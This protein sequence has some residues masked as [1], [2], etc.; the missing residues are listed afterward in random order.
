ME[1][2]MNRGVPRTPINMDVQNS[3]LAMSSSA[4]ADDVTKPVSGWPRLAK[5]ITEKPDL[6]SFPTFKDLGIKSLLY[7]QAELIYLR[8][9]LHKA[10]WDDYR[11][12]QEGDSENEYAENLHRFI[13]AHERALKN[14]K[15]PPPQWIYIDRIRTVLEK[16]HAALL[17]FSDVTALRKAD[18][19]NINSLRTFVRD[20]CPNG[21]SSTGS[22]TW[23]NIA[24]TSSTTKSLPRLTL[25]LLTGFFV[26]PDREREEI[27]EVFQ[28]HL[29]VPHK[30]YKPDGLTQW[31]KQSFIPFFDHIYEHYLYPILKCI[32]SIWNYIV[33]LWHKWLRPVPQQKPDPE[34]KGSSVPSS[35]GSSTTAGV[36]HIAS[37]NSDKSTKTL[38]KN[39]SQYSGLCIERI[40]SVI[41][42]VV[43][44][45][46][47]V[48]AITILARVHEMGLILGLI[49][50][51]TAVFAV[52][53]VLL[54]SSS[55]RVEIFTATAA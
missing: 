5:I 25:G 26:P 46:L 39:L 32:L 11:L 44:C 41:T 2:L 38:T 34:N 55:S 47:P 42:T 29:I 30:D 48:V 51:F 16:Y 20:C 4:V 53:L 33:K 13:S 54:S 52:G 6:E 17:Q 23:G 3:D 40:A 18:N 15:E 35:R 27:D 8:K 31:V 7:Y 45:L 37:H 14:N 50:V 9:Q 21:L 12:S 49:A 28:E 36:S 19:C 10:E 22:E 43:A 24:D 1:K